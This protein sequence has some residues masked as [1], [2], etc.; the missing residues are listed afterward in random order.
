MDKNFTND[1]DANKND[2]MDVGTIRECVEKEEDVDRST[3][4]HVGEDPGLLESSEDP[5]ERR[6]KRN[7]M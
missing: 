4:P 3:N 5:Q 1:R 7:T 6:L 2:G